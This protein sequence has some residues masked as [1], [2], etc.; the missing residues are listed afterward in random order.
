MTFDFEALCALAG[1]ARTHGPDPRTCGAAGTLTLLA[2]LEGQ[3]LAAGLPAAKGAVLTVDGEVSIAPVSGCT[4]ASISVAGEAARRFAGGLEGPALLPAAACPG[5]A[6]AIQRLAEHPAPPH[7]A[8]A[9]CYGLLCRF[10]AGRA[11][12][13]QLPPLVAAAMD[14][15]Q[16]HYAEVFGV[17]ELADQLG[18]SKSHLIRTFT[19]AVG[20][21]PGKYLTAVRVE[22]ARR[23][24]AGT[25]LPLEVVAN[26][27][28]FSGGNY[29]CKVFKKET[30]LSPSAWRRMATPTQVRPAGEL[31]EQLYL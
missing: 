26:L 19:A 25:A 28:G 29:L 30:G 12:Q 31:E 23:L 11:G 6:E 7:E 16:T 10:A 21:S 15:L 13:A 3:C 9:I 8:S 22:N 4:T 17:D 1:T 24:L 20:T 18:V 27:C 14:E 2:V 5:A